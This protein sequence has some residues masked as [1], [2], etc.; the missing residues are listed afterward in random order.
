VF[1]A[2]QD[3]CSKS[4]PIHDHIDD[5]DGAIG[6]EALERKLEHA[7]AALSVEVSHLWEPRSC[8]GRALALSFTTAD[9]RA[10]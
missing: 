2:W 7:L 4:S 8:Q 1:N 3:T 9:D 5:I 10:L 6:E